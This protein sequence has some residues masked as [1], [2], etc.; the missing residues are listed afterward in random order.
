MRVDE[1]P[2]L[3]SEDMLVGLEEQFVGLHA[4]VL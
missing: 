1:S 2:G 3:L 4:G